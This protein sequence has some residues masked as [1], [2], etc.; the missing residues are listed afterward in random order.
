MMKKSLF[1]NRASLLADHLK[2]TPS[3]FL[4][5]DDERRGKKNGWGDGCDYILYKTNNETFCVIR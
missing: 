5:H 1:T 2:Y 4:P 3:Q